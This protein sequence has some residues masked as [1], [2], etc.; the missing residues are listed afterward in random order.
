[1][2]TSAAATSR[3]ADGPL[4]TSDGSLADPRTRNWPSV[5]ATVNEV[6]PMSI[7]TKCSSSD[8][9]TML[10]RRPPRDAAAPP[11]CAV[12]GRGLSAGRPR[13]SAGHWADPAPQRARQGAGVAESLQNTCLLSVLGPAG[14][15]TQ[16]ALRTTGIV[17]GWPC[18]R[19]ADGTLAVAAGGGASHERKSSSATFAQLGKS[20]DKFS[21]SGCKTFQRSLT[22]P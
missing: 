2:S 6:A 1:L 19:A 14:Q 17:G 11:S 8:R 13:S 16:T 18:A 21:K 4:R 10:E 5:T 15:G 3:T 9:R 12:R 22:R 7:P 20:P